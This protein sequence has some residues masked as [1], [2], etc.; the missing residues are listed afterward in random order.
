MG[1]LGGAGMTCLK[2]IGEVHTCLLAPCSS[3]CP[4][5]ALQHW[6][7]HHAVCQPAS[8]NLGLTDLLAY[9]ACTSCRICPPPPATS[10]LSFTWPGGGWKQRR[11]DLPRV[12]GIRQSGRQSFPKAGWTCWLTAG[13]MK[14]LGRNVSLNE[15][16]QKAG[17]CCRTS[18]WWLFAGQHSGLVSPVVSL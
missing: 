10:I 11:P 5:P 12:K 7:L 2:T 16:V 18:G 14:L 3:S 6:C 9:K 1:H 8:A 13:I 4:I 17:Y 15:Y